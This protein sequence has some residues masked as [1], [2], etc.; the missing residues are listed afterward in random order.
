MKCP[1]DDEAFFLL[2]GLLKG[3]NVCGKV[4]FRFLFIMQLRSRDLGAAQWFLISCCTHGFGEPG[5]NGLAAGSH[6]IL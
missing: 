4:V 2:Q 3:C 1:T 5:S 6:C